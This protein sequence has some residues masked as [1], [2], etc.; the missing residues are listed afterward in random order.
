LRKPLPIDPGTKTEGN[1]PNP[2]LEDKKA[3]LVLH[4]YGKWDAYWQHRRKE[5]AR[6]AG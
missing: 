5:F 4:L 6:Y 3:H 2:M 1:I